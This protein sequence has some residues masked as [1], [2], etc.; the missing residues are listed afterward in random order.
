MTALAPAKYPGS[1]SKTLVL[2]TSYFKQVVDSFIFIYILQIKP[3]KDGAVSV[4]ED[5]LMI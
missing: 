4:V 2:V 5:A 1:S 3:D